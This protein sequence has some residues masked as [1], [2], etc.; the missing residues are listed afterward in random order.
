MF[1]HDE[2]LCESDKIGEGTNIWAFA[3]VL[4]GAVIG[5][6][7]NICDNVFIENKVSL[8]N[9]VTIKC[10]VQIWDGITIHDNVFIGPNVTFTNDKYPRSKCYPEEFAKTIIEQGASL[11][12]NATILPGLTIGKGAMIG[13]G[14]V[15]TRSVPPYATVVGNPAK[16]I[17]YNTEC[18][19]CNSSNYQG[20]SNNSVMSVSGCKLVTLPSFSD[21]RGDLTAMEYEKDLPFVPQ[22][23]FLVHSVKT[24][25]VRGEHAHKSCEQFLIAISGTLSVVVDD[26]VNRQEVKLNSPDIGLFI[27]NKVWGIQYK[28]SSDA[29]LLVY[30]SEPYDNSDYIREYDEFCEYIEKS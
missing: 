28:F 4:P 6:N 2:A 11:G 30:A 14:S 1:V 8:G 22:R 19:I 10:G 25:K 7:C 12:A 23:S 3:H 20:A 15:V 16:I 13:A 5:E 26:G 9:N 18:L 21:M 24:D 29:V 17:N 27:P